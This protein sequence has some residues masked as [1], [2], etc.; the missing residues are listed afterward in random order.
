MIYGIYLILVIAAIALIL[1]IGLNNDLPN[2]T[3]Q[4]YS[5]VVAFFGAI[6][7][8]GVGL[9]MDYPRSLP[10]IAISA[11]IIGAFIATV[12]I[13]MLNIIYIIPLIPNSIRLL[14]PGVIGVVVSIYLFKKPETHN[15]GAFNREFYFF[16]PLASLNLLMGVVWYVKSLLK[17]KRSKSFLS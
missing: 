17:N 4:M 6:I 10:G 1:R 14:L 9:Y 3:E 2:A 8:A 16:V 13:T 7:I 5:T 11:Y 12:I 15:F